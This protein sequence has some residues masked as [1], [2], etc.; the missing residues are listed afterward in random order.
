MNPLWRWT[1]LALMVPAGQATAADTVKL[2]PTRLEIPARI[3]PLASDGVAHGFGDRSLGVGYQYNG[4]GLSLTVYVYDAGVVD[5]PDGGDTVQACQQFEQAKGDIL[6]AGYANATLK[7]QQLVRLAPPHDLPL[8]REAVLEYTRG[9]QALVSYLWMTAFDQNFVKL[10]FSLDLRLRDEIPEARRAVLDALRAAMEPLLAAK[11]ALENRTA[12]EPAGKN[13]GTS[14]T[15]AL[16]GDGD[17]MEVGILYTMLVA[18]LVEQRPEEVPVCGGQLVPGFD[19]EVAVFRSLAG[20]EAEGERSLFGQ[21]LAD[22]EAVGYLEELVWADLH[23]DEW[24]KRAP[25][26]L[27]LRAYKSWKKKHLKGFHRP[28]LGEVVVDRPR[29]MPLEPAN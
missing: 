12:D 18:G 2:A 16:G 22:A 28:A 29:P 9:D 20:M 14:I 26:G 8:A 3:G 21:Q 25:K 10:R 4:S 27:E 11:P 23:R 24:G 19:A 7:S 15:L 17:D 6:H 13:S 1:G 5:I